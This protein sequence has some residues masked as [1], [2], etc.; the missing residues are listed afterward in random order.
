MQE[1]VDIVDVCNGYL[2]VGNDDIGWELWSTAANLAGDWGTKTEA[3]AELRIFHQKH[4]CRA[5]DCY[6]SSEPKGIS[7]Q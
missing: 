5:I 3:M 1:I 7:E 6:F 2:L 4:T